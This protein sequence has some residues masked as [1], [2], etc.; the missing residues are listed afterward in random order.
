MSNNLPNRSVGVVAGL[1]AL[2]GCGSVSAQVPPVAPHEPPVEPPAGTLYF[3]G[4]SEN[5]WQIHSLDIPNATSR[6]L[7][8]T[9]GDKREP[10]WIT[11]AKVLMAR[12]SSGDIIEIGDGGENGK[13]Y[14][15]ELPV[16]NFSY[17]K[18]GRSLLV[19]HLTSKTY[20]KQWIYRGVVGDSKTTLFAQ[21]STGSYRSV[22]ISPDNRMFVCTLIQTYGEELLVMGEIANPTKTRLVTRK[23][24]SSAYPAWSHN[25]RAVYFSMLRPESNSWDLCR[26]EVGRGEVTCLASTPDIN[27]SAPCADPTGRGLFFQYTRE[28]SFHIG[29][30]D[31]ESKRTCP[32]ATPGDAKEP[33]FRIANPENKGE[34]R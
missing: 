33:F 12:D 6:Q 7:T 14:H 22:R 2:L 21:P 9:D 16:A 19:T 25:G 24:S 8:R 4:L 3:S 20:R 1:V 26:A 5:V 23:G 27:E 28:D 18:D 17:F 10:F 15:F 29:Y 34:K 32:V 30:M 13:A 11:G 31:L